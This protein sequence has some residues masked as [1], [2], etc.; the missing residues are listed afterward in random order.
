MRTDNVERLIRK[1]ANRVGVDIHRHRPEASEHG[2][3]SAM[4]TFHGIN[5]L[6]DVGANTGQ[7]AQSM[8][9]AGYR[10]RIVSFE[11][12]SS[13]HRE[14]RLNS[15]DDSEWEVAPP[16]AI[17]DREGEIEMHIA[18]NSVSSSALPMLQTHV[19]A[20]PTSACIGRERVRL[21]RLDTAARGYLFPSAMAFL[22]ID[23]QGYE[24]RVLDGAS[25]V[26]DRIRGLQLELSLVPL[27]EGQ[28][29]FAPLIERLC[30]L[31]FSIWAI[32][33]GFHDPKNGRMLQMDAT[34]FRD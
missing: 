13:A 6:L 16:V 23:T 12:L 19:S 31:G 34:F 27:Y 15:R 29:L 20:V 30:A 5:L 2:R 33:P 26:L 10:G 8:R 4:L 17:G 22:K 1:L 32:W 18:G 28:H 9:G 24:D 14:L 25:H 11:P 7:F 3:L 21:S